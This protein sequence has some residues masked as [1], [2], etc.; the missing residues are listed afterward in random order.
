MGEEDQQKRLNEIIN[1]IFGNSFFISGFRKEEREKVLEFLKTVVTKD[2]WMDIYTKMD[3]VEYSGK[4]RMMVRMGL[5]Q[6]PD[7]SSTELGKFL[8]TLDI[9]KR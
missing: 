6:L 2:V 5:K 7:L 9:F 8:Y 1:L 4:A 3:T